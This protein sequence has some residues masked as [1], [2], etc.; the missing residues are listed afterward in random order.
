MPFDLAAQ[1]L[2]LVGELRGPE[3]ERDADGLTALVR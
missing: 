2:E 1:C 3:A